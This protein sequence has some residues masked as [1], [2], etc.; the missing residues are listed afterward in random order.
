VPRLTVASLDDVIIVTS[1]H[2]GPEVAC[3]TVQQRVTSMSVRCGIVRNR[4]SLF[5]VLPCIITVREV[6]NH[7][8]ADTVI[9]LVI[10]SQHYIRHLRPGL[11]EMFRDGDLAQLRSDCIFGGDS[12]LH[13]GPG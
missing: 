10:C 7:R 9:L 6:F 2:D 5:S 8:Q 13:L 12:D 11:A 3:C 4:L 1:H